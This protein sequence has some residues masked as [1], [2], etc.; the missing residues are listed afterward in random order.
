MEVLRPGLLVLSARGAVRYFGSEQA[1][2]ERLVDAV[3]AAGAECQIGIADEL[4]TAV[5]A[6]RPALISRGKDAV[7]LAPLPIRQLAAEP[8][9]SAPERKNSSTCCGAWEFAPSGSSRR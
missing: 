3:A 7:F 6:A 2:A 8:S 1:A 4:P 5:F 9:L